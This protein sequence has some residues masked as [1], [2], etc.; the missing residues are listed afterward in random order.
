MMSS[1]FMDGIQRHMYCGNGNPDD[2]YTNT[3]KVL[4]K[5]KTDNSIQKNGFKIKVSEVSGIVHWKI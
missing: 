1:Q 5:F 2:Y 4:V 3:K